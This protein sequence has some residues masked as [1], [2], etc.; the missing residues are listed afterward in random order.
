[1]PM[2]ITEDHRALAQTVASLL[3]KHQARA[4]AR[5]LLESRDEA[6][7]GFWTEMAGLRLLGLH[8]PEGLGGAGPVRPYRDH[9]RPDRGGSTARP[10]Q[11]PAARPGRGQRDRRGGARRRRHL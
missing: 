7:P 9:Q 1:M 3:A 6:L 11:A 5:D 8:P 2:S 10:A 4:A